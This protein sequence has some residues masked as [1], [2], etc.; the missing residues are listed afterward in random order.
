MKY[1]I[2]VMCEMEDEVEADTPEEAFEIMVDEAKAWGYWDY[3][4]KEIEDEEQ[5]VKREQ[6]DNSDYSFLAPGRTVSFLE[7]S[8]NLE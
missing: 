3:Q 2:K 6:S 7:Q 4:C 5:N 1:W 8:D